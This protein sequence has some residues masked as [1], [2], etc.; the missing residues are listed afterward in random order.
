MLR[1]GGPDAYRG[2]P[3]PGLWIAHCPLCSERK[4][5]IHEVIPGGNVSVWCAAGC[6]GSQVV[7]ELTGPPAD[8]WALVAELTNATARLRAQLE[9]VRAS[10]GDEQ[11]PGL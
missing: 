7:D 5:F 2:G 6:D 3:R 10:A 1:E 11:R 4:L 8:A 9:A